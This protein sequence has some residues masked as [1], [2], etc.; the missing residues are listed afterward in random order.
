MSPFWR[1]ACA[2]VRPLL[3]EDDEGKDGTEE[4][5]A[6]AADWVGLDSEQLAE[7]TMAIYAANMQERWW[8]SGQVRSLDAARAHGLAVRRRRAIARWVWRWR[9]SVSAAAWG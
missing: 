5:K 2:N 8:Q 3:G 6:A 7:E 4:S 9:R 1:A